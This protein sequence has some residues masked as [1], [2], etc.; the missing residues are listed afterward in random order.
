MAGLLVL[1]FVM[2]TALTG[3]SGSN[4]TDNT[5]EAMNV[6]GVSVPLGEVNFYLRYQ[7]TQVQGMYG[8]F[9]GEDFM[10]Q[11]LMGLGTP[12]GTTIRDTVAD[13]L[14]EYYVV[15]AHAE[16][17][18]V[19]LTEEEKEQAAEAARTFLAANDS[20]TLKAMSADEAT[21]TH[22]LQLITLQS[23]VYE[24]RAATIDTE[25]DPESVAQKRISYVVSSIA[26]TTDEEGNM[27]ELTEDEIAEKRAQ[28]ETILADA[29]A[30][31][32]LSAAAEA[33]EM[34]ASSMTY[35]RDDSSLDEA[36][37]SAADALAEGELS[38]IIETENSYYIVYMESTFD[39]EATETARQNELSQR[40]QDA[41]DEWYSPLFEE[42]EITVDEELIQTLTF[43]R[44]FREPEEEVTGDTEQEPTEGETEGAEQESIEE[45]SE[46]AADKAA[47]GEE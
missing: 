16:E 23:K 35:G 39:E 46:A 17:L 4:K 11:D 29:K 22:V 3:C 20:K 36:V 33:Q 18:G 19:S 45:E 21:V 24:D 28:M 47:E 1:L 38:D 14:Q 42:T 43:E 30:S 40:E 25:V 5:A 34:N 44:I 15:E 12:Y 10:N 7:Q 32:D 8:A 26:G 31:G 9:F 27:T 13:T 41:Y 2:A 37:Q 6:G